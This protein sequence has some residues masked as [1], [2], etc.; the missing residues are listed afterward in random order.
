[1]L[2]LERTIQLRPPSPTI[3]LV[4]SPF[5]MERSLLALADR[6]RERAPGYFSGER[7]L[8]YM[9]APYTPPYAERDFRFLKDI[10]VAMWN[11]AG[12]RWAHTFAGV[13]C[14]DISAWIGHYQE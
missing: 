2:E 7:S 12:V 11:A 10:A 3:T 8:V 1:M 13:I 4:N 14:I 6:A 5:G 9:R